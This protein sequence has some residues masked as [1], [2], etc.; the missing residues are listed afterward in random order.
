MLTQ[1]IKVLTVGAN[2]GFEA[3]QTYTYGSLNRLN[4]AVESV[5]PTGGSASQ[6]WEQTFTYDRY[7][8]RRFDEGN[9]S[10]PASF[11]NPAVSNPTISTT[12]NRLT[13]SGYTYD[14][15][16]NT[17]ADAGGQS[18]TYDAENKMVAA[19]NGGGTLGQY[20]YDGDGKRIKKVVP[21]TGETTIFV[22]D[23]GG[24]QV[25]EYS[26]IVETTKEEEWGQTCDLQ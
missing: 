3:V 5:T 21:G 20:S 12:T 16:G 25:A 19:S 1:N 9:T 23:A 10:M 22:Y 26:T 4:D 2:T 15:A 7:G 18:Y 13:S 11:S 8:N 14:N 6:S 24:K 17:T